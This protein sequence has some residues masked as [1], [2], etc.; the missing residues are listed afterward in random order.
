MTAPADAPPQPSAPAE[1]REFLRAVSHELR[2]PLNAI[3]GFSQM[4][5]FEVHG[6]FPEQYREYVGIIHDNGRHMLQLVDDLL[7]AL[8]A[9]AERDEAATAA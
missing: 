8:S 2:T 4:M 5:S 1:R 7:E 3:I 9:R 6:P